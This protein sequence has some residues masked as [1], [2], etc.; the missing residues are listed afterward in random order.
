MA[1]LYLKNEIFTVSGSDT[2]T[3]INGST[4]VYG[5][6][7]GFGTSTTNPDAFQGENVR[8]SDTAKN[9]TIDANIEKVE[10]TGSHS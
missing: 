7:W 4:E 5:T 2:R 6:T 10:F 8:L 3:N 1:K 9:V